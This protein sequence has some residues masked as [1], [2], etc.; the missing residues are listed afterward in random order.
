MIN[1][2]ASLQ[3]V[4]QK[5]Q[6]QGM[7]TLTQNALELARSGRTSLEEVYAVRLE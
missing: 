4:K 1:N 6:E 5:A 2:G 7:I 3:E